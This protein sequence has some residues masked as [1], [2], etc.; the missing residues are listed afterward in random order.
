MAATWYVMRSKPNKEEFLADQLA[1]HGI[2]VYHPRIRVQPVN[3]RARRV[4]SYFPGYLFVHADL[5][6][7]SISTLQWMPGT[8]RLVS[9][10]GEPAG[11]PDALL[12]AIRRRVDEINGA[13]GEL[14]EGLQSGDEVI[15][16]A[17]A[18]EGYEAIFDT[19]IPGSQRV[20]VLLKLL[21]R[22]MLP[23]E[24]PAGQVQ[25]KKKPSS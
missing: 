10:G 23:L 5:G 14:F 2:E 8:A 17:G 25:P 7:L 3:P 15:L 18:F 24:L 22:R 16:Q 1:A 20:R 21:Q 11:V 19:R 13:G 4:R 12:T 9:Y 6:A